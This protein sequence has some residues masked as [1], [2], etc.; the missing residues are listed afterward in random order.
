MKKLTAG[1]FAGIL[2]IVT[3]NAADAAITSKA[4]VDNLNTAT[5]ALVAQNKTDITNLTKT[6]GDN[7]SAA[8]TAINNL[9]GI[10]GATANDGLR[11]DVADL[12]ASV[13]EGGSVADQI[14]DALGNSIG[15]EGQPADVSAALE[16][17]ADKT[18]LAVTDGKVKANE[19]A[20]SAINNETTGIL[21]TSKAYTDALKNGAVQANTEAIDALETATTGLT[22][23][24]VT[25]ITTNQDAITKLNANATTEGSVD[26]KIKAA[27]DTINTNLEGKQDTL[28]NT[29]VTT[30][31]TG[32][33][34]T[35]I[36]ATNGVVTATTGDMF[37]AVPATQKGEDGTLVLTAKVVDGAVTYA[38]EDIQ[39]G[40]AE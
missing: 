7:K 19:D 15:G 31:G 38:W 16:L 25:Q 6:V 35:G 17:K 20:I 39:R 2:T 13:G 5:N 10:V 34:I 12:Q 26:Y 11:K 1:I 32:N 18:A 3:V 36:S 37:P 33:V 9:T 27:T 24:K 29:N 40:D 30:T 21:V 23:A 22:A 4:Y 8:D 14:A 28:N